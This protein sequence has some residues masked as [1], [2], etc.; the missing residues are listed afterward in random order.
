MK[1]FD[2]DIQLSIGPCFEGL[3]GVKGLGLAMQQ[4]DVSKP[5]IVIREGNEIATSTNGLNWSRPPD[6]RM[7]LVPKCSRTFA[8]A[9][10]GN[11]LTSTL[12]E[13]ARLAEDRLVGGR[14]KAH[15][16]N[17]SMGYKTLSHW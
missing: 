4:I 14:V 7:N 17:E 3:V 13:C 1:Y 8:F 10:L 6:V 12:C 16:S 5:R 2:F 9:D 11:R 15:T